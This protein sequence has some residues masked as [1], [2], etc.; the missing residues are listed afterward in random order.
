MNEYFPVNCG[1][2]DII[3]IAAT[4]KQVGI[5]EYEENGKRL[6][7]EDQV[8]SWETLKK[9]EFLITQSGKRIRLDRIVRLF[10]IQ[11]PAGTIDS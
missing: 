4:R 11:G 5:I 9:E 6:R 7:I 8:L 1:F 3:E 2:V 10:G